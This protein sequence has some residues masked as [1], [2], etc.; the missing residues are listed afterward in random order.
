MLRGDPMQR[1]GAEAVPHWLRLGD[2]AGE[3]YDI[4][5]RQEGSI[6]PSSMEWMGGQ[7]YQL[8]PV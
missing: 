1:I 2:S 3:L 7:G 4:R 6:H 8:Y 5:I